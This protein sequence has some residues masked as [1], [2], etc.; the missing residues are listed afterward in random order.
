M[1]IYQAEIDAGLETQIKANASI[2][3]TMPTM[4][5]NDCLLY[6][7]TLPTKSSV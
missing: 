7:S 2:A 1:K 5:D 6:T 3:Y 4:L